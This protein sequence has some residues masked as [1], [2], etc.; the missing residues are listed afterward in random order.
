[1]PWGDLLPGK[2]RTIPRTSSKNVT[3]SG[4]ARFLV[5][6]RDDIAAGTVARALRSDLG[7]VALG[8][9]LIPPLRG[10]DFTAPVHH[11]AAER[12]CAAHL[13]EGERPVLVALLEQG[14][15]EDLEWLGL[16]AYVAAPSDGRREERRSFSGACTL[17]LPTDDL[18]TFASAVIKDV[19]HP[20]DAATAQ[21]APSLHVHWPVHQHP[22]GVPPRRTS[23]VPSRTGLTPKITI[24][25]VPNTA[26]IAGPTSLP[27]SL[28]LAGTQTG[29]PASATDSSTV[30]ASATTPASTTGQG[31]TPSTEAPPSGAGVIT[32]GAAEATPDG[33]LVSNRAVTEPGGT[34]A[35]ITITASDT[36]LPDGT[37]ITSAGTTPGSARPSAAPAG[38]VRQR[39]AIPEGLPGD[40]PQ[41]CACPGC[42]KAVV[43][44]DPGSPRLYH[45]AECRRKARRLRHGH[46]AADIAAL[47]TVAAATGPPT[48]G[49]PPAAIEP[50]LRRGKPLP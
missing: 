46:R 49:P 40:Q 26:R 12:W 22:I 28:F 32:P 45:S 31:L 47:P 33:T 37:T 13:A 27:S 35:G 2:T 24:V 5:I 44:T 16:A 30:P 23:A 42:D 8:R 50:G 17:I 39:D 38:G 20:D 48:T 4:S 15:L 25:R 1:M 34:T 36:A 10:R 3:Q 7:Q 11:R 43:Q 41:I 29:L 14:L 18:D 6:F 9:V 19:L 21:S